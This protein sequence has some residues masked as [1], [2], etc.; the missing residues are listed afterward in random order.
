MVITLSSA[1]PSR[2]LS[3]SS[4]TCQP[5]VSV[6]TDPPAERPRARIPA[7]DQ[8]DTSD[9]LGGRIRVPPPTSSAWFSSGQVSLLLGLGLAA[10]YVWMQMAP[11]YRQWRETRYRK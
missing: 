5:D 9:I 4:P 2:Q 1:L 3:Y 8:D 6:A 11:H 10:M 7:M